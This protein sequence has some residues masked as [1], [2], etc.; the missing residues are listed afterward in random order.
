V[1]FAADMVS[2]RWNFPSQLLATFYPP[3]ALVLAALLLTPERDWPPYILAALVAQ[4]GITL[5]MGQ[6]LLLVPAFFAVNIARDLLAAAS[7]RWAV[8]REGPIFGSLTGVSVFTAVAFVAPALSA[9]A[10]AAIPRILGADYSYTDAWR[11]WFLSNTLSYLTITPIVVILFQQTRRLPASPLVQMASTARGK[12]LEG[13]LLLGGLALALLAVWQRASF[14][15]RVPSVEYLSLIFVVWAAVRF[16]ALGTSLV[17]LV[18]TITM[19]YLALNVGPPLMRISEEDAV[20]SLQLFLLS[21]SVPMLFLAAIMEERERAYRRLRESQS[22]YAL[23]TEVGQVFVYEGDSRSRELHVDPGLARLLHLEPEALSTHERWMGQIHPE[24]RLSFALHDPAGNGPAP[25]QSE[26]EFRMASRGGE[27]HWFSARWIATRGAEG[28]AT[29]YVGTLTDV[30]ER[31]RAQLLA[32]HHHDELAHFARV[33]TLGELASSL[34]HEINQPLAAIR[35]SAEAARMLLEQESPSLEQVG[36]I[37]DRI[38]DED[39]RATEVISRVRT[40]LRKDEIDRHVLEIGPLVQEV[41]KLLVHDAAEKRVTLLLDIAPEMPRVYGD[42]VQL[43]QV[44]LNLVLNAFDATRS[45]PDLRARKPVWIRTRADGGSVEIAVVDGGPG[46]LTTAIEQIFAPFYTTKPDGLGMGLAICR[47]IVTSHRGEIWARNN[48][49]GG[50]TV[51]MTLPGS[52]DTT[53][54]GPGH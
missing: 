36:H 9:F 31:K 29:S 4:L 13:G 17:L 23:A 3:S 40:L 14:P 42:R 6:S 10:G 16:G 32:K 28:L 8:G 54:G 22:R 27:I 2:Q 11:T 48:P 41:A 46:I 19:M 37:L 26:F 39:R 51:G 18:I 53:N 12:V 50:A 7:I 43:Q 45:E 25:A 38:A 5:A 21:T 33:A 44:M 34:A 52:T 30:T 49:E 47:S 35:A 20:F 1:Y 15:E 24:D